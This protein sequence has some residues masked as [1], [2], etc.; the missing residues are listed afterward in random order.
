MSQSLHEQLQRFESRDQA[1]VRRGNCCSTNDTHHGKCLVKVATVGSKSSS[2]RRFRLA[3]TEP[4]GDG[5]ATLRAGAALG[6]PGQRGV[7]AVACNYSIR[8]S[9]DPAFT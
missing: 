3:K 5:F 4:R 1:I 9:A 2:N 7:V 8:A 6:E